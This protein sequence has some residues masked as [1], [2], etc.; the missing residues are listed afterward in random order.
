MSEF[1]YILENT[2]MPGLVKIGRTERSVSERVGELSSH[3]G[4]PTS[5]TVVKEYA[6]ENSVEA[7]KAIH[8]R[9]SDFRVND[10]R[11]FFKMEAEDAMDIIESMLPRAETR[12]DYEREDEMVA[13]AIPIVVNVGMAR[14]RMLE[15][16]LRITYEEALGVIHTLRLRGI[17]DER[18]VSEWKATALPP[19][20]APRAS[21]VKPAEPKPEPV[22]TIADGSVPPRPRPA[23][24]KPKPMTVASVPMIG[25]YQLPSLDFLQHADMTIR[26]T[27]SKEELMANAR[28]MQQTLA[29]HDIEVSLGDITRGPTITRYELHPAPGV[30]LDDIA[31]LSNNLAAVL[32][33]E[34]INI[35]TPLPDKIAVVGVDVGNAMKTKVIMRD[36]FES[37]EWRNTKAR[38][39]IALGKDVYGHPIVADL[40]EMPH[41]LIGG[42]I[43]SGKSICIHSIIASLLYRFS[44]DQLRFVMVDRNGLELQQYNALPHLVVPVVTDPNKT[45]PALRW[46]VNEME[47]RY[48]IFM[49]VGVRNI[50]SFNERPKKKP[51][52]EQEIEPPSAGAGGFAVEV[53]EEIVVPREQ[54]ILIPEKLSYIV[55]IVENLERLMQAA[56]VDVETAIARITQMARPTGIHL[57]MA[58]R[59]ASKNTLS[60]S[61]LAEIPARIAFRCES[62]IDSRSIIGAAGA[63]KLLGKGDSLYLP[64]GSAKLIRVQG[65]IVSDRELERIVDFIARQGRPSYEMEINRQLSKPASIESGIDEDE[66]LVQQC[67]EVIRS[68]QK[69]S[70]S[71]LQRRLRLG[72]TR[73]ARIM[74]EL[75]GRGI[76]GESK[77]AEPREILI[78]LDGGGA[79][80]DVYSGDYTPP[81]EQ[82]PIQQPIPQ[83]HL[84]VCLC[85][86]CTEKI[87][88]DA[89]ELG[90]RQSVSV[91]CPHCGVETN[92][93][94]QLPA[95]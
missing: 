13:R 17:I 22:I 93:S 37:D 51:L 49:R 25:N 1:I 80:L 36:L 46:V 8:E 74:D 47:K 76:V 57:V 71:L 78:D 59:P 64:P 29:Q 73:C 4:V 89:N 50:K 67:I 45:L 60:E 42:S 94:A 31:A 82:P 68:E 66:E 75:E 40:A 18:N 5:F 16:M 19:V 41:L 38:I 58:T 62:R 20:I 83:P 34:R 15:E 48:Q 12:H 95:N 77:G 92:L 6:V 85:E 23:P 63:E 9:L 3:T 65:A 70:V 11:E 55:V 33:V 24:K 14:P 56:P 69:A 43:G 72:Y 21:P 87:E 84:V 91:P 53:D 2:L 39:P 88:F 44:P 54:D 27:E 35:L 30:N 28:L 79:Y 32:K 26:P 52:P 7:E 90:D 10:N 61:A 81:V 86:H